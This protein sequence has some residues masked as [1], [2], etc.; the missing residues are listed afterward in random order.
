MQQPTQTPAPDQHTDAQ[1][2]GKRPNRY[3]II[4]HIDVDGTVVALCGHRLP[5]TCD[6][7]QAASA[8]RIL[9]PLCDATRALYEVKL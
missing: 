8:G 7:G 5:P 1:R 4:H 6:Q 9:C 3:H 2:A